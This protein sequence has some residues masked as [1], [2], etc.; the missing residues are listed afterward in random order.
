MEQVNNLS[1]LIDAVTKFQGG[2]KKPEIIL[3]FDEEKTGK[4]K[5]I[6]SGYMVDQS[7]EIING[8]NNEP[9]QFH[10]NEVVR[11]LQKKQKK[12]VTKEMVCEWIGKDKSPYTKQEAETYTYSPDKFIDKGIVLEDRRINIELFK[13]IVDDLKHENGAYTTKEI[14][15]LH[16]EWNSDFWKAQHQEGI[17]D[18]VKYFRAKNKI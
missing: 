3:M 18:A 2:D 7:I 14:E 1:N 17:A 4:L 13:L 10:W 5:R 9:F 6:I 8:R 12:S 16:S 15:N 11:M